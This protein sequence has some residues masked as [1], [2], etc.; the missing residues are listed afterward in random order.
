MTFKD[1]KRGMRHKRYV[2]SYLNDLRWDLINACL[3]ADKYGWTG[4][5]LHTIMNYTK[6]I[7]KY[8]RRRKWLRL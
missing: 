5:N 3:H 4:E 1:W 2:I 8:E 6:L 7:K